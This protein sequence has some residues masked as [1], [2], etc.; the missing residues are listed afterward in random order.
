MNEKY[1]ATRELLYSQ[2]S[3]SVDMNKDYKFIKNIASSFAMTV[4]VLI[5]LILA[6]LFV[7]GFEKI[8]YIIKEYVTYVLILLIVIAYPF[9]S[10]YLK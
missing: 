5:L 1:I 2:N 3:H 10:K 7:F 4:G 8:D 6:G 9:I